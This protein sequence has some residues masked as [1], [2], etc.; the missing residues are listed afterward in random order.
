MSDQV[1]VPIE[2]EDIGPIE[3]FDYA[4]DEY[5]VHQIKGPSGSGKSTTLRTVEVI[6]GIPVGEKPTARRGAKK[7][8]ATVG[9]R[10]LSVSKQVRQSGDLGFAEIGAL[11]LTVI[12]W[13]DLAT[14]VG[15]DAKRVQAMVQASE[16]KADVSLFSDIHGFDQVDTNE[17]PTGSLVE[18]AG[19]MKRQFEKLARSQELE[20][21]SLEKER[22]TEKEK[23]QGV[24]LT[25]ET[26]I[27]TL[28]Q[29]HADRIQKAA[30]VAQSLKE[31][32]LAKTEAEAASEWLDAN[33]APEDTAEQCETAIE[34]HQTEI[35]RLTAEM[36]RLLKLRD[37]ERDLRDDARESLQIANDYDRDAESHRASVARFEGFV[38]V[39]AEDVAVAEKATQDA[40]TAL[41]AAN[42]V[43]AAKEAREKVDKL[44]PEI[45]EATRNA[46]RLRESAASAIDKLGETI[47]SIPGSQ[48]SATFDDSGNVVLMVGKKPFDELSDGERWKL[49]VP[50]VFGPGRVIVIPQDAFGELSNDTI[51][52]L[53]E[54]AQDNECFI[55]TARVTDDGTELKGEKWHRPT[56][57]VADDE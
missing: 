55:L 8:K 48:V 4:L 23:Y 18:L 37:D 10:K 22:D 31:Y 43:K 28:S 53:D 21:E 29:T 30:A 44:K 6:Q 45:K 32:D 36:E 47:N 1:V 15:R 38:A 24:D 57:K 11:D 27:E 5:G 20:V 25:A 42:G 7:G 40:A 35:D 26:D 54:S 49:V 12:H 41:T 2:L 39:S 16:V 56:G 3:E 46:T 33:Q 19:W 14:R 50:M 9:S 52:F 34:T 51:E 13:P 17:A